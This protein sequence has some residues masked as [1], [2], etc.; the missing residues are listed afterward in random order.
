MFD[1][2][3]RA[4]KSGVAREL[5]QTM[6]RGGAN[7]VRKYGVAVRQELAMGQAWNKAERAK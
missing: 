3:K 5:R 4:G 2:L 6:A 1:I 7:N